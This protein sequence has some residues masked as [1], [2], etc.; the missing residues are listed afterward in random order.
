MA[1]LVEYWITVPKEGGSSPSGV[2]SAAATEF[3]E[4]DLA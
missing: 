2:F 1:Q 4:F 3:A